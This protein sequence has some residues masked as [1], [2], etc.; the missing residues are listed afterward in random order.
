MN[1]TPDPQPASRYTF[2]FLWNVPH[3]LDTP[4]IRYEQ[5]PPYRHHRRPLHAL[6]RHPRRRLRR[7]L[8]LDLLLLLL[9]LLLRPGRHHLLHQARGLA[10]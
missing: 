6:P 1:S 3:I 2:Q 8:L 4:P 5:D 9:L 7:L 10:L